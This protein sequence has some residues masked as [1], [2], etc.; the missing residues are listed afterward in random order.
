M[1]RLSIFNRTYPYLIEIKTSE[2]L[3]SYE[4]SELNIIIII[5]IIQTF[6]LV[7]F[8]FT[9]NKSLELTL[10]SSSGIVS[11]DSCRCADTEYLKN[12]KMFR[13]FSKRTLLYA[14]IEV[15]L[16]NKEIMPKKIIFK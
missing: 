8:S 2:I 16:W 1:E 5:Y 11:N 14:P 3:N 7:K 12:E 13:K 15:T 6:W 9:L 4:T 10:T